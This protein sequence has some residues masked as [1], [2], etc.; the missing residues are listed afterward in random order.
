MYKSTSNLKIPVHGTTPSFRQFSINQD[1]ETVVLGLKAKIIIAYRQLEFHGLELM[2]QKKKRYHTHSEE[3]ALK[4]STCIDAIKLS[5][6][7]I[8]GCLLIVLS[9]FQVMG[10]S[11]SDLEH[12]SWLCLLPC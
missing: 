1:I 3:S 12:S 4:R 2:F 5:L 11:P 7:F 9:G 8:S 6:P 10:F